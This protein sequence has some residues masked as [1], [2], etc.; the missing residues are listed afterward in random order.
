MEYNQ[1][2][3]ESIE[4][5]KDFV[6][7]IQ[8]PD[9]FSIGSGLSAKNLFLYNYAL[10]FKDEEVLES[11]IS[12]F[13]SVYESLENKLNN[14]GLIGGC[15][16][17]V[18][19][20]LYFCKHG[21]FDLDL[22]LIDFFD[23]FF[24]KSTLLEKENGNYDLFY[25][26]LGYAVYFLQ[27]SKMGLSQN[28]D[29]LILF[30]D[31]L[32]ET[33]QKDENGVFWVDKYDSTT[34]NLGLAHGIPSIISFLGKVYSETKYEKAKIL[35]EQ[36]INWILSQKTDQLDYCYFPSKIKLDNTSEVNHKGSR[37]AWC[38]GDLSI[39]H[40][41]IAF[42][43][44]TDNENIIKE[45][46]IILL[47]TLS[48]KISD[49]SSSINDKGFCHGTSGVFYLYKKINESLNKY[50]ITEKYWKDELVKQTDLESFY[51]HVFYENTYKYAPDIGLI[52]GFCGIGLVLLSIVNEKQ[53]N[54]WED[55][56]MI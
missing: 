18:W 8:D 46:E 53:D 11:V 39:A 43:Q 15:T 32:E 22:D 7:S 30:V 16:G 56:F 42:G 19:L 13:E 51:S 41:I 38:Y 48:R 55:I 17:I 2:I 35:G 23:E 14:S 49:E 5:I 31:S 6:I 33:A 40:S 10:T 9:D 4:T 52:T 34:I 1:R 47:K 24:I 54:S 20:Y 50:D 26:F 29:H 21:A 37:M 12:S 28:N 3:I 25:G 27:K 36:S 45:G 44:S